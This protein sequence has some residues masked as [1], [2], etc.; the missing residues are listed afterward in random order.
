MNQPWRLSEGGEDGFDFRRGGLPGGGLQQDER[1]GDGG[2][3][4]A[5]L[6]QEVAG[7]DR[8]GREWRVISGKRWGRGG[9]RPYRHL[10]GPDS[11]PSLTLVPKRWVDEPGSPG[12]GTRPAA[13]PRRVGPGPSP[14]GS[15][16]LRGLR[17]SAPGFRH[18]ARPKA[19]C[20]VEEYHSYYCLSGRAIFGQSAGRWDWGRVLRT[21]N[22]RFCY[23]SKTKLQLG[24]I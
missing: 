1:A 23:G 19:L 9:T 7:L 11:T 17:N 22:Q 3:Q 2:A 24:R 18:L 15:S 20:R 16:I 4:A 13:F 14:G 12:R 10:A 6:R 21:H 8:E 5:P